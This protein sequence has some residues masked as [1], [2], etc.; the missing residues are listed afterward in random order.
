MRQTARRLR[1][2]LQVVLRGEGMRSGGIQR[3]LNETGGGAG[4]AGA[5]GVR[6]G[7]VGAGGNRRG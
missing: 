3:R 2:L 7:V 1:L 5:A 6:R 4:G